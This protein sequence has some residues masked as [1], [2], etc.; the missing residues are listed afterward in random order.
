MTSETKKLKTKSVKNPTL[1]VG[2]VIEVWWNGGYD[3]ITRIKPYNNMPPAIKAI[4]PNG[5]FFAYFVNCRT[6]MT[7]PNDDYSEK[8]IF[9]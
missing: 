6:G 3:T 4:I 1:K 8:V 2:D 7:M 9:E 5:A